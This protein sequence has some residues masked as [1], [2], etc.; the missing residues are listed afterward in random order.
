MLRIFIY[1]FYSRRAV[2][3]VSTLLSCP[4]FIIFLLLCLIY[5][6]FWTNKDDDTLETRYNALQYNANLVITWLAPISL[7]A[8]S[9][10]SINS[11][12]WCMIK[13]MQTTHTVHTRSN[14]AARSTLYMYVQHSSLQEGRE[15]W[16]MSNVARLV[17]AGCDVNWSAVSGIWHSTCLMHCSVYYTR[18]L[19]CIRSLF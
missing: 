15:E 8:T 7:G 3:V 9:S 5:V 6:M 1:F 4:G 12:P 19:E 11:W 13:D 16:V 14:A 2:S 18:A 17:A 10:H